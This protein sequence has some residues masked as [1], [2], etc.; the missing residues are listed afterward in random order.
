MVGG[1]AGATLRKIH[2]QSGIEPLGDL[3]RVVRIDLDRAPKLL[4]CSGEARQHEHARVLRV[5]RCDIFLGDEVHAVAQRRDEADAGE[6]VEACER[7]ARHRARHPADRDPVDL[8][9]FAV[10]PASKLVELPPK[11]A[12]LR[13]LVPAHRRHLE[14]GHAASMLRKAPQQRRVA[15]EALRQAFGVVEP[16][17]PEDQRPP[18]EA[19]GKPARLGRADG[20]GRLARE[21]R[22]IHAD[23]EGGDRNRR[24]DASERRG[25]MFGIRLGLR[26]DEIVGAEVGEQ[27]PG[28]RQRLEQ[29]GRRERHVQ[30]E[31]DPLAAAGGPQRSGE[32]EEVEIVH[33]DAIVGPQQRREQGGEARV[34]GAPGLVVVTA[35]LG[36]P[37]APVQQRP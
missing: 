23:R 5:L 32:G 21:G 28:L 2:P 34:D 11:G 33:P 30:E 29:R 15:A 19:R 10:D 8:A 16:V 22:R 26:A 25:E 4:G 35:E 13:H 17:H 14:E 3:V 37:H 1:P 7:G 6:P 24:A 20:P 9:P 31:A 27:T 18:A 12:V 36:K